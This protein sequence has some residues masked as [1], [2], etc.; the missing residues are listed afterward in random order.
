MAYV[1]L[2]TVSVSPLAAQTSIRGPVE[3]ITI[4]VSEGTTLGFDLSPDGRWIVMDLL[5]QL[6]LVP[7]VGGTA[8][9][10]TNRFAREG[11][12]WSSIP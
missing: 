7:A 2:V 10:V 9:P 5:G 12:K 3:T 11:R 4:R 6:W 1:L 8:R